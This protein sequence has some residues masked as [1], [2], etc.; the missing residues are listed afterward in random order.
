MNTKEAIDARHSVRKFQDI[1]LD[2]EL[3]KQLNQIIEECNQK[4]GLHIQLI[5]D[6]PECFNTL[7]AH[8]GKFENAN[9]Y[10]ALVGRKDMKKLEE[11][12]GYYGQHVALEVQKRGLNTCWVA[13]TYGK[14]KCKASLDTNEKNSLRDCD[15]DSFTRLAQQVRNYDKSKNSL[16]KYRNKSK[17][18]IAEK[19][20]EKVSEEILQEQISEELFE[21]DYTI[22]D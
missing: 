2:G 20:I 18:F 14:S 3:V 21:R 12:C 5:L 7:L 16:P 1:S 8:Y 6:D 11:R 10:I 13:G 17:K 22:F 19:L 9:N 4:S 15:A